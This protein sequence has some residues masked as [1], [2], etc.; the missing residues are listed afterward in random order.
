MSAVP[1]EPRPH[2]RSREGRA[3]ESTRTL[4]PSAHSM[5]AG[6]HIQYYTLNESAGGVVISDEVRCRAASAQ[7]A[8]S[9]KGE[10]GRGNAT[11]RPRCPDARRSGTRLCSA[12]S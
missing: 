2:T 4:G 6:L 12:S 1:F 8:E 10:G 11:A 7:P 3:H 9:E 5:L